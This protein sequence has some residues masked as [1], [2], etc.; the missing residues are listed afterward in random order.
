MLLVLTRYERT[1]QD[2]NRSEPGKATA[3][4]GH[5]NAPAVGTGDE[6]TE[7]RGHAMWQAR[8]QERQRNAPT[9]PHHDTDAPTNPHLAGVKATGERLR[10][11]ERSTA[12]QKEN[13][14]NRRHPK[15]AYWQNP[16]STK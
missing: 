12:Q 6:P 13:K 1:E 15:S 5:R 16:S 4:D 14:T 11:R 3:Q 2:G 8:R 7:K 9:E 10:H